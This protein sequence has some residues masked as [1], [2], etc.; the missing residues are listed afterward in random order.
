MIYMIFK[1]KV[2]EYL[3]RVIEVEAEDRLSAIETV[4]NFI[5]LEK[6]VLDAEDFAGRDIDIVE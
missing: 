1:V 4:E 2:T 5:D 3:E 6:V